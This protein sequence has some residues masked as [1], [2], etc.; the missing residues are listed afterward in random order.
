VVEAFDTGRRERWLENRFRRTDE[1][2]A[3]LV[4]AGGSVEPLRTGGAMAAVAA[5]GWD[6]DLSGS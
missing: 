2:E 6:E 4:R 3:L 5:A 1:V